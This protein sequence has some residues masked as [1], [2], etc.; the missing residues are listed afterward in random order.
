MKQRTAVGITLRLFLVAAMALVIPPAFAQGTGEIRGVVVDPAGQP[1]A[2]ATVTVTS[3]AAGIADR[4][5]VSDASGRVRIAALPSANDYVV[6]ASLSGR[7][8]VVVSKVEVWAGQVTN[9][10]LALSPEGALR[11]KVEVRASP[12]VV[13]P[14]Q[15]TVSTRL[16]SEFL[17]ALP[18]L[19]RDYQDTLTL[20]PGVSDVDGD[21]NPNIHGA[22]DTDVLT[23]VD[24][25]TT[26]DP[27]TGK[28][29]ARL[30][31]ESIE[32]IEVKTAGA[33]AEFGRAQGGTVNILTKSGGNDF[34]GVFKFFWR[35]SKLDGDGAGQ[36]PA[37]QHAGLGEHGLR[38]LEFND[39][40]PF[41]SLS[42]PMVKDKAWYFVALEYIHKEDPVNALSTAFVT[43][44]EEWRQFGKVTAQLTP[45]QRLSFSVNHDPQ[46][47]LNQGLNSTTREEAGYTQSAG[48]LLIAL[49]DT[50]VLTP[51]VALETTAAWFDGTPAVIPNLGPDANGNGVLFIDQDHDRFNDARE[52][53]AGED[54]DN[55]GRFDVYED[56]WLN[57]GILDARENTPCTT[58]LGTHTK[59][60]PPGGVGVD[61]D[62]DHDLKLTPYRGCEGFNRED[63]DCDG[64]LDTQ[65][66]DENHNGA[67]DLY[68]DID[69]DGH[70]DLGTEDRNGNG[71][72]DDAPRPRT[73][74]PYGGLAPVPMDRD[75]VIDLFTGFVSGPFFATWDDDRARATL[76]QD[77]SVFTTGGGTHDLKFGYSAER[78]SFDRTTTAYPITGLK[79]PG[80]GIGRLIDKIQHPEWN[81]QCNNY[82]R[83]CPDPKEGRV[84]LSLPVNQETTQAATGWSTG[85]YAQDGWH[86]RPNLTL[87]LGVR[88]DRELANAEGYTPFDPVA[89]RNAYDRLTALAGKE[90][91]LDDFLA[92][93]A[94]GIRSLGLL[95][96]PLLVGLPTNSP[97]AL[98]VLAPLATLPLRQLTMH[99]S[100]LEFN[101][102]QLT[103]LYPGLFGSG[104][105]DIEGLRALG[106]RIAA[107]ETFSVTN[108]NLS[109][110]LAVSWDPW[111]DGRTKAFATWGRYY[112]KLFLNTVSDE[113]A[114]ERVLRYYVY[115]RDGFDV[116]PRP[117]V[118]NQGNHHVGDLI[119]MSPPSITQ[120][121]RNLATPYSDEWMIGFEREIA[122]ETS[123]AVRYIDRR[124]RDQLQDVDVNHATR[125]NPATG[126]AF[127]FFGGLEYDRGGIG[128]DPGYITRA[129]GR[130][131]LYSRNLF[132]NE[133]LRIGNYNS[134]S[135]HGAEIELRRRLSRRWQLQGSYTYSRAQGDAEDFQSRLGNDPSTVEVERGYL[136]Y[137]Q[138]HVVKINGMTYLPGDWQVGFATTWASGL[139]YSAV[140]R[141]FAF[142]NAGYQQFRTQFGTPVVEGGGLVFQEEQRNSR[143]NASVLDVSL[144]T[145]K[146]FVIGN[147][148][149]GVFL[150]VFNLLNSDDLRIYSVDANR[151]GGLDPGGEVSVPGPIELDAERRFG[152]RWQVGFQ[153]AF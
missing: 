136:D 25:V 1:L 146:N 76:R 91:G 22:R 119:R 55:D 88:F 148:P 145:S 139:P 47:Y 14:S 123:L 72:Y 108:N 17:D 60:C 97:L 122:P 42:G 2:G 144:R 38:D 102:V 135:Y 9:L 4:G 15:T 53:D 8:T 150:E 61:E 143:R 103:Q 56:W 33:T 137:D 41:L 89:E 29:G 57:N 142:D 87:S 62:L 49:R 39:Y 40:L 85:L 153:F 113:Q 50:A 73:A 114:T 100:S 58:I 18:I 104:T 64:F 46:E 7:A 26:T 111:S 36:D 128:R 34:E 127:D 48:G 19:G 12:S 78:E 51:N 74:Y 45:S 71:I 32:A 138:R 35:S 37:T 66:E 124:F 24:G 112:D 81:I 23:Q 132:L 115:D 141:F 5:A 120:V 54:Y 101:S 65:N 90:A 83:P 69:L 6:R 86:P 27:L 99:R 21:G 92:G 134:A 28:I 20:A 129:D 31:I 133:V 117:G 105:A 79:D 152:R 44:I 106:V 30:N 82:E 3:E 59:T 118:I 93:N 130:P 52:R 126:R 147:S 110:R 43:G 10:N 68:E 116:N 77:L 75:Y 70:L 149:A 95:A 63:D 16:S 11:E 107:P 109:P 140:S 131:D 125:I 121:D 84:T 94:D 13:D 67:L 96:D 80:F 98:G 151:A